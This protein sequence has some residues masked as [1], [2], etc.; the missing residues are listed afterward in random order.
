M[1][2]PW[3]NNFQ[4]PST[5]RED[6]VRGNR[7]LFSSDDS[8]ASDDDVAFSDN[9]VYN[10]EPSDENILKKGKRFHLNAQAKQI[11]LNVYQ[12]LLKDPSDKDKGSV[13]VRAEFLTGVPYSSMTLLIRE[14]IKT[15]KRRTDFGNCRLKPSI[16]K[17]LRSTVYDAY[18]RNEIPTVEIINRELK[19]KDMNVNH[20]TLGRWLRKIGFK[21]QTIN[22]RSAI[23]ECARIVRWRRSYLD[24]I[25]KYRAENRQI[26]YLDETWYDTH[27]TAKKGWTDGSNN[28][29]ITAMAPGKGTRLVIL[30]CGSSDG[31]VENGLYLCGKNMEQCN[32][33]YHKNM[34]ACMF[35]EWFENTLIPKLRPNSVIVLDN[36]SYH[37]KQSDKIPNTGSLKTEI[38]GFLMKHELYYEDGYTKK[39]LL[40]VLRTKSFEKHYVV[41]QLAQKYGHAVLRLPPYFCILNP[42]ELIWGQLK[43]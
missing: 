10:S 18:K 43:K 2:R 3:E 4:E 5:S 36:A 7:Y 13:I 26:Y 33:D 28:C 22:K 29:R 11:C 21:F 16:V 6:D 41:D 17:L 14:G 1:F 30:H 31:F 15:R 12:N 39:Q 42:I 8:S 38:Q 9:D 23:M 24:N 37:S 20:R 19:E 35:E 34:D 32:V 27:D 25:A 40:E